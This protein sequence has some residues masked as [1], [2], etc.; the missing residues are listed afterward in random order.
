MHYSLQVKETIDVEGAE[1]DN[2]RTYWPG[3]IEEAR[4]Q[5]LDLLAAHD[6]VRVFR[7]APDF[8]ASGEQVDVA[9]LLAAD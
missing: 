9:E 1:I 5:L 4:T 7:H 2:P 3:T 8:S 6:D